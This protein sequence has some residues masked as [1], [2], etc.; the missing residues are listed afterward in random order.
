MVFRKPILFN[1]TFVL[2]TMN[3][4]LDNYIV[5]ISSTR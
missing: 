2:K 5:M 3:K 1:F 4:D